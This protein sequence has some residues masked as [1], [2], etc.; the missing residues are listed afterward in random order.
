MSK[1]CCRRQGFERMGLD[2][3]FNGCSLKSLAIFVLILNRFTDI[4]GC[5]LEFIIAIFYLFCSPNFC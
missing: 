1:C 5:S 2:C 4:D 3:G